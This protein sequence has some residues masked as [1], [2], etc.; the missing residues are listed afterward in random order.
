MKEAYTQLRIL[1][2]NSGTKM[3]FD[4]KRENADLLNIKI[5]QMLIS[6]QNYSGF[7]E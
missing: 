2:G 1:L 3:S 4:E 6:N 5:L 7:L